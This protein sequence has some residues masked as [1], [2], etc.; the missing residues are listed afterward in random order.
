MVTIFAWG[1]TKITE[2]SESIASAQAQVP[3]ILKNQETINTSITTQNSK[4]DSLLVVI[5]ENRSR[6]ST[7]ENTVMRCKDDIKGI[8][9]VK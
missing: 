3:L 9:D 8:K 1:N 7:V 6:L 2:N 4:M 5:Y